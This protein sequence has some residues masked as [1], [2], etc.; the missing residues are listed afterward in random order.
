MLDGHLQPMTPVAFAGLGLLLLCWAFLHQSR[1]YYRLRHFPGPFV[2]RFTNLQR[3]SW[4]QTAR[5]HE[6][7]AQMHKRYGDFVR[8]G[9][10]MVSISDPN[11]I[12]A[13]YPIRPGVPKGNF[14]RSLMPY[15]RQG[16]ALPLVFNTRDEALHKK[17]KKPIA[18]IFSLSN[19]LT[20]EKFVDQ[21]LELLFTQLDQRFAGRET[22]F[23]LGDWL[24]FFAF[25]VMGTMTFSRQYGFLEKGCD[26]NGLLGAIWDFMQTAAPVRA[27]TSLAFARGY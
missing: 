17:M 7:H 13:V 1:V 24:Q 3:V 2:A 18:P 5:S 14:Y 20:F 23:D 6:I 11:L 22:P 19:V 4:V 16:A 9:P 27:L 26:G 15:S 12:P 21:I 10:N 8:M 25:E